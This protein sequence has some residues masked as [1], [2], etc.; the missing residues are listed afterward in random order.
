MKSPPVIR[1][2]V[3][4]FAKLSHAHVA[5]RAFEAGGLEAQQYGDRMCF[6]FA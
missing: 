6:G 3:D 2:P 5:V 1:L 4:G